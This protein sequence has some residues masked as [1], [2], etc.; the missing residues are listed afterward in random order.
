MVSDPVRAALP[1]GWEMIGWK[2]AERLH[3]HESMS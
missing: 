1:A 2:S 3:E